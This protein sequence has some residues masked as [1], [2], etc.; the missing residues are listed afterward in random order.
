[1]VVSVLKALPT[2]LVM[3]S[4]MPLVRLLLM[5]VMEQANQA[6]KD[7]DRPD[8]FLTEYDF[9]V[10]GGGSAGSVLAARL[11]EV[12]WW[13]VLVLEAGEPPTPETYVPGLVALGYVRGNNNWDYLTE[14]QP[15]GLKNFVDQRATI[16]HGRA[17]GGGSTMGGMVYERGNRRDFDHWA[18][19]GNTG[20]DYNSVLYHFMKSENFIGDN[21]GAT[22]FYHGR[23][24]PLAVSPGHSP[25]SLATAF[26]Q[27]GQ[28]LGYNIIDPNGP[29][30]LGFSSPYYNIKEG[31]RSSSAEAYLRP[32]AAWDNLHILH[33]ATVIKLYNVGAKL[34]VLVCAGSLASPKLLLLSGLGPP[35]HLK[36]HEVKVVAELAGVGQNLQDHLGVY[37]LSWT[38]PDTAALPTLFNSS[39][40]SEYV[41]HKKGLY[42]APVGD[43]GSA[44]TKVAE[45][46]DKDYPDVELF[47]SP[48]SFHADQGFFLP[49]AY[50]LDI[51]KYLQYY[52]SIFGKKG[53]SMMVSLLR[54]KSRGSLTLKSAD[55]KEKPIIDP[56]FLS[57]Q[58]DL[59]TLAKGVK[60][61]VKLGKTSAFKT[62]GA[63]LHKQ[64]VPGCLDKELEDE[65]WQCFV[66]HMASSYWH[67]AGTCKMG[68]TT[69]PLAVVDERL[70]VYGVSG[71]RVVDASIMPLIVSGATNAATIM[72]A[73]KAADLI[74]EDWELDVEEVVLE[75]EG[76]G[77]DLEIG[78]QDLEVGG[79]ELDLKV[80]EGLDLEIGGQDLKV[81]G[82]LDLEIEQDRK[83]EGGGLDLEIEGQ[84]LEAG[85]VELDLKVGEGL[86]LEIG[87]QDLKVGG[88][89]D[90]EIEQDLKVEGGGLDLKV[91]EGGL[92][93]EIGGQ[94]L[95]V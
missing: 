32:A 89:L 76:G 17:V 23:G 16:L 75:V 4:V 91:E 66:Q 92:D 54:P 71:L 28:E 59:L 43:F 18:E 47:L 48:V 41:P 37:G 52:A 44:W 10:V 90:L 79:V 25:G 53:F 38:L 34:E 42:S 31:I 8:E 45:G 62:Q 11:A 30:T 77:L 65:Y 58:E 82:G 33:S 83:V 46:G 60:F 81:G 49:Y 69:D 21:M 9:I 78:G 27:A 40:I 70:K 84:D 14:P 87:G 35:D 63:E 39:A 72:I 29:E 19:L 51:V 56:Q 36:E 80:G 73:E 74:K 93:L 88:E 15:H 6:Y 95:K 20:W 5:G 22:E 12:S 64:K 1:M 67:T 3:V 55:P 50:G 57:H 61:A 85:G 24:G 68:P 2:Q 26:L 94:D 7:Y 13:K 86:D